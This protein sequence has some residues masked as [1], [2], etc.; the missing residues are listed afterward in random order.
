M[1]GGRAL[2]DGT[3]AGGLRTPGKGSNGTR[4]LPIPVIA[5]QGRPVDL[6][7]DAELTL[8]PGVGNN[9]QKDWK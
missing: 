3:E 9:G 4:G 7:E 6:A 8:N 2:P 5:K 1:S